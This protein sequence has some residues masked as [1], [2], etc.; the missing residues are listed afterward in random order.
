MGLLSLFRRP[1][2]EMRDTAFTALSP[3]LG[4][5]YTYGTQAADRLAA[6][7]A[8]VRLIAA[9]LSTLP[10]SLTIDG[11]NG[12]EPAPPSAPAWRLLQRP[13]TR[14]SW[15][16]LV[17]WIVRSILLDGNAILQ[18]LADGR[19]VVTELVPIPWRWLSP[20]FV[21]S[22]GTRRLVFDVW[23]QNPEAQILNL[24]PR[25][26]A[27]EALHFR[28]QSDGGLIGESVLARARGPIAEGLAIETL[29]SATWRNGARP[30]AV[31]TSPTMLDDTR[32][33][34]F[35][36]EFA[37]EF[38][39]SLNAGKVPLLEGGW[40]FKPISLN[41]VDAEFLAT[42]QLN[43]SQVAMLF[44]VPEILLHIGQRLPTDMAPFITQFAQLALAPL[45]TSIEAEF[46]HAVLPP[47]QH[48][49]IDLDGLMRGNFS[50]TVAALAA[51]KQSGII[52]ANDARAELDWAPVE[53]GDTLR[54]TGAPSWPADGPGSTHLGPS[55]GPTGNAPPEPGN[56]GDQG[57]A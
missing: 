44:G 46:D 35:R 13:S 30:S 32:R 38:V 6:V 21:A 19:G 27:D 41:S 57:A 2:P 36:D 53:G 18:V 54:P 26:L 11:A 34:R 12:R 31:L 51:L 48:L 10:V 56:H 40:E 29:A 1:A 50:S 37:P 17:A 25:L 28:G 52:S 8:C 14:R 42:R 45:V 4:E 9:A 43:T 20:Q 39:G 33:K 5:L 16:D 15:P 47:G 22:G 7:A 3:A 24:P 49:A 55:P 23:G